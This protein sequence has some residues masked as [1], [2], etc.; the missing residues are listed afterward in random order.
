MRYVLDLKD[1]VT[2][3]NSDEKDYNDSFY[4]YYILDCNDERIATVWFSQKE[5]SG[6]IYSVYC[7]LKSSKLENFGLFIDVPLDGPYKPNRYEIRIK[8]PH[9]NEENFH[10]IHKGLEMTRTLAHCVMS[11][12]DNE[13]HTRWNIK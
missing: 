7:Q 11:I 12:F 10:T 1:Y 2:K 3:L 8:N 6:N 13:E 4:R 9:I 5:D